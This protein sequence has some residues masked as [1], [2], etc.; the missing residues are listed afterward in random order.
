MQTQNRASLKRA[1]TQLFSIGRAAL[2]CAFAFSTVAN[3]DTD[4]FTQVGSFQIKSTSTGGTYP[5]F[6]WQVPDSIAFPQEFGS[7][8]DVVLSFATTLSS[9]H[10]ISP[11]KITA[12]GFS[13]NFSGP[14]Y[15]IVPPPVVTVNWVAVGARLYQG[16]ATANYEILTVIYAPPGTNGG[17]ATSSVSYGSGVTV[18]TTT[19]ASNS[20]QA[21]TNVSV[22]SQAGIL[23]SGGQGSLSFG[24]TTS[25]QSTQS[26]E[27]KQSTTS[28]VTRPGPAQDGINHEEDAI[29]LLLK[30]KI[31]LSLSSSAAAWTFGDNGLSPIIYVLVGELDGHFPW[32]AG[33][34][35]ELKAAGVTP[36]DYPHIL[37]ADPL[38]TGASG[39][40]DPARF[41]PINTMYPYEPPPTPN[42]PVLSTT[43]IIS[44]SVTNT[45]AA[46][47][48]YT[49]SAGLTLSGS[50]GFLGMASTTLKVSTDWSWTNSNS[51]SVASG[52]LQSASLTIG[53]PGFGYAGPVEVE[54]YMDT[55][56][57][58]F[59]FALVPPDTSEIAFKGALKSRS[60]RSM[61]GKEVTLVS[62]GV[63]YRT[64]TDH[65]GGYVFFGH[66][67]GPVRIQA[68]GVTEVIP[69]TRPPQVRNLTVP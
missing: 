10:A 20:F 6:N 1:F 69:Q 49:Y 8:P 46:T 68:G 30:P 60:G 58:T 45:D 65:Q 63:T 42:D 48:K 51:E 59:A 33:V 40:L 61:S 67:T 7:I 3:A 28:T 9:G 22:T 41:V 21:S 47:A 13:P 27:V 66:I 16:T 54:V 55:I 57:N 62:N 15:R 26:L 37:A 36:S 35:A 53:G 5:T 2:V 52:T 43:T 39:S 64:F 19:S 12:T 34:L 4:T 56:Y 29:Y 38:A 23:G 18:G 17:R 11:T 31:N 44:G 24:Y 32:R 25:T 50:A 14:P